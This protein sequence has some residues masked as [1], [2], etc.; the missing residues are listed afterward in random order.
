METVD[1]ELAAHH[2]VIETSFLLGQERE[3][4]GCLQYLA[5]I[6]FGRLRLLAYTET[7]EGRRR[8]AM[9]RYDRALDG[10][11]ILALPGIVPVRFVFSLQGI[12][13]QCHGF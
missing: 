6:P 9:W 2:A 4:S 10:L 13:K 12:E 11:F 7:L 3:F 1:I 5:A 8:R